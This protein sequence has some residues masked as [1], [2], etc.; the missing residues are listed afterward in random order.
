MLLKAWI[1]SAP[2]FNAAEIVV[3]A[4]STSIAIAQTGNSP[5]GVR[6]GVW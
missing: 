6:S 3:V 4:R 2:E 5:D 1:A